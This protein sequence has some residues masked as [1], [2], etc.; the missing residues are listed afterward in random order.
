MYKALNS[1][2]LLR[3]DTTDLYFSFTSACPGTFE[4]NSLYYRLKAEW[5]CKVKFKC[6]A[7]IFTLSCLQDYK[8]DFYVTLHSTILSYIKW[9]CTHRAILHR[10]VIYCRFSVDSVPGY[11]TTKCGKKSVCGCGCVCVIIQNCI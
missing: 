8:N 7:L 5:L 10:F 11:N 1:K 9:G 3:L 2:T 6:I 4:L